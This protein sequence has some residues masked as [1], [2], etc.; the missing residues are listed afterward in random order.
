MFISSHVKWVGISEEDFT[1]NS[2][3]VTRKP[4]QFNSYLIQGK[5]NYLIDTV[6]EAYAEKFIENLKSMIDIT[7]LSGL[8]VLHGEMDHSGAILRLLEEVPHLEIY[9]TEEGKDSLTGHFHS[10]FNLNLVKTDEMLEIDE[11]IKLTFIEM[12]MLHWPDNMSAYLS[13]DNILFSSDAFGQYHSKSLIEANESTLLDSARLYYANV[14]TPFSKMMESYLN[15]LTYGNYQIDCIAPAHGSIWRNPDII[16]N[17][18]LKWCHHETTLK[19]PIFYDSKWAGTKKL[20][21][22][23]GEGLA[24]VCND[25]EIMIFNIREHPIEDLMYYIAISPGFLIGTPTIHNS[26]SD[27][28]AAFLW[29]L[30]GLRFPSKKIGVFGCH[31]W[32]GEGTLQLKLDLSQIGMSV[33][34]ETLNVNWQPDSE[35]LKQA[36]QFT[37]RYWDFL[38][39]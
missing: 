17:A 6:P 20:A 29:R 18:Y 22:T 36:L 19:I 1:S 34:K 4:V 21:Q 30:K 32:T 7:S 5:K 10:N 39:L 38:N 35:A 24:K 28:V 26:Y 16:L 12:K 33:M 31:G 8:I 14:F 25:Y 15:H 23:I 27:Q 9:C 11:Q 3:S 13:P 2:L 37:Q